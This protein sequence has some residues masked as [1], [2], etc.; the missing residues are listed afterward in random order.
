M[1]FPFV[2][3]ILAHRLADVLNE[4]LEQS[5]AKP[6]DI[7]TAYFSISGY[8]IVKGGLHKLG[9]FR[10]LLGTDPDPPRIRKDMH[11]THTSDSPLKSIRYDGSLLVLRG[12][13]GFYL[14]C[15]EQKAQVHATGQATISARPAAS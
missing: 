13:L 9:G 11:C 2:I 4:L 14:E 3:D 7:A 5:D 15:R 1:S 6:L 12:R 10:L 8:R